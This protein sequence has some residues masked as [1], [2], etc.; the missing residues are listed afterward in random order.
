LALSWNEVT[1]ESDPQLALNKFYDDFNLLFN[2]YVPLSTKTFNR[3]FYKIEPWMTTGILNSRRT[4]LMLEKNHF[5]NPSAISLE[6]YRKFRNLYNKVV[7]LSKKSYFENELKASQS[8]AKKSWDLI[9]KALRK[10]NCKTST[11]MSLTVNNV[12]L[13]DP[14]DIAN[15]F[16]EFFTSVA[17]NIVNEIN[18][19]DRPPDNYV[20]NEVPLFSFSDNPIT[21]SEIIDSLKLL[22]PKKN[23]RYGWAIYLATTKGHF[24]DCC[25][26]KTYIF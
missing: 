7:K 4:K 22:Q 18:P 9:K 21:C 19:T 5:K 24:S 12:T 26:V 14:V 8:N 13:T 17:A 6:S 25:T 2:L 1:A 15:C 10:P 16:N 3:N 11:I 23:F 20:D